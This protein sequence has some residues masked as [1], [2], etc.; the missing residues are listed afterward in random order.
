MNLVLGHKRHYSYLRFFDKERGRPGADAPPGGE[1]SQRVAD[2]AQAHAGD[3]LITNEFGLPGRNRSLVFVVCPKWY[4][5][6]QT[7]PD[8]IASCHRRTVF[9]PN[10]T[11]RECEHSSSPQPAG[12]ASA[13]CA[14]LHRALSFGAKCLCSQ[15][16]IPIL[17]HLPT[18]EVEAIHPACQAIPWL[19]AT[20][21][22]RRV[23]PPGRGPPDAREERALTL[24]PL[25]RESVFPPGRPCP[26]ASCLPP[27][28]PHRL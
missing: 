13:P 14:M 3:G 9:D 25:R 12:N 26:S 1:L 5:T 24:P 20:G 7:L 2:Q 19:D 21:I 15:S 22:A 4:L 27:R 23:R 10:R 6:K 16:R 11:L 8:Q 17:E 18:D 28:F